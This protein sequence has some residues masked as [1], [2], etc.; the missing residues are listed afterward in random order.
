VRGEPIRRARGRGSQRL[1]G[2]ETGPLVPERLRFAR[3]KMCYDNRGQRDAEMVRNPVGNNYHGYS[4]HL[5]AILSTIVFVD[6]RYE[7]REN[8][9]LSTKPHVDFEIEDDPDEPPVGVAIRNA[10]P[11]PAIIKSVTFF[12]DR[13]AVRDAD[14][15][16]TTYAKLTDKEYTYNEFDPYDSLAG[17]EKVWLLSYALRGN[18]MDKQRISKF[19]DS[20]GQRLGIK[21]TFYSVIR[22]ALCST[23]C[24]NKGRMRLRAS[25]IGMRASYVSRAGCYAERAPPPPPVPANY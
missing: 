1:V 19:T 11:G 14:D 7:A 3:P 22:E 6:Q 21:V 2:T 5:R 8:L 15:V 16:A 4:C 20:I 25:R 24:T 17:Q 9:V 10:G 13:K 18:K 23:K 12:V